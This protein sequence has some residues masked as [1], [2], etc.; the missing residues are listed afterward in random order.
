M[1]SEYTYS[2]LTDM[3]IMIARAYGSTLQARLY[4]EDV[5]DRQV[6][7][8]KTFSSTDKRFFSQL[9]LQCDYQELTS[10]NNQP[11]QLHSTT[12]NSDGILLRV[13]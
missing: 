3:H 5:P 10:Q 4:Q 6:P 8:R 12:A 9:G 13:G 2:E 11:T 1:I 7:D